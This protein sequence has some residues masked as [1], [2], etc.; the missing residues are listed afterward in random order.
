M[1]PNRLPIHPNNYMMSIFL[2]RETLPIEASN[3]ICGK[4]FI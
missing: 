2:T 4:E 1:A 3:K